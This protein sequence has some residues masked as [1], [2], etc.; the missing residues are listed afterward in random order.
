MT[1]H[2]ASDQSREFTCVECGRDIVVII[3]AAWIKE[4]LCAACI[5]HPGWFTDPQLRAI[6]HP[7]HD[8]KEFVH[9]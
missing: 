6:L 9:G 1:T 2:E 3:G 5:H 7:D 4:N 8:G